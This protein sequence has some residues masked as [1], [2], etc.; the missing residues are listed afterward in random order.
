MDAMTS[1]ILGA[2]GGFV[3]GCAAPWFDRKR[4]I[5]AHWKVI[6]AE[7]ELCRK[8]ALDIQKAG[9]GL[10]LGRL[11][12]NYFDSL[13]PLLIVEDAI[14]TDDLLV[15]VNYF[16]AVKHTNRSLDLAAAADERG[17]EVASKK[18][19]K[20]TTLKLGHVHSTSTT[21]RNDNYTKAAAIAAK[22]SAVP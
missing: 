4:K 15:L 7:I 19:L 21:D 10:T 18:E 1:A 14:Q 9:I 6:Q 13:A 17:D 5:Q 3:L 8:G 20:R 16:D 11:H 2:A 12:S 22:Y